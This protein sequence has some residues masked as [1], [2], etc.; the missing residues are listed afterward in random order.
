LLEAFSL[1]GGK[2]DSLKAYHANNVKKD[3]SKRRAP[4]CVTFFEA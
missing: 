1:P 3:F 2:M 4:T